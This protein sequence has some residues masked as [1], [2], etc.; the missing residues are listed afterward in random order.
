MTLIP[1]PPDDWVNVT[2]HEPDERL[3]PPE[4]VPALV[5]LKV[6]PPEGVTAVPGLTSETVAVHLVP[7]FTVTGDGLQLTE[8]EV[9]LWATVREKVPELDAWSESPLY[10]ME[11]I[12]NPS[13]PKAGL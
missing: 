2:P 5:L 1:S 9:A 7:W 12:G 3:Q 11:T 10:P 6:I 4:K 8:V 13:L